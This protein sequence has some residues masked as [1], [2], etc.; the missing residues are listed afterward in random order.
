MRQY[1]DLL[2]RVMRE[3]TM[4]QNRTGIAAKRITGAMLEF[5][6]GDGFPVVTTKKLAFGSVKGELIGFLRGYTSA[7]QF[8]QLGCKVWDQ[9]ANENHAWIHNKNRKGHD[10]LG[11]IYGA[12]WNNWR[13]EYDDV[14]QIENLIDTI[15][16]DPTSRR[17]IVTAWN[18]AELSRM[19]LPPCHL[20]F[21]VLINEECREMSMVMYQRSCDMFLGIPFNIASYA[22][23]LHIVARATGYE[24]KKLCMMLA[25]VHVYENHF[26]QV[27]E[28][29][30][31]EPY[32]LPEIQIFMRD[33]ETAHER[34]ML[35]EPEDIQLV[36]YLHHP[37]IT[38]A[39]AV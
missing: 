30:N 37:A 15:K 28:Q 31:R 32:M 27:Q 12:Q 9:N 35:L 3:G 13:G 19:A 7:A 39:M 36:G 5:D 23:L 29:R 34:I 1:L 6:M 26:D 18:P 16:D 4:Q 17:M 21:Q 11:R 14:Y 38:G 2:E 24:P 20:L 25:D 33:C 22:L 10:D 8:R